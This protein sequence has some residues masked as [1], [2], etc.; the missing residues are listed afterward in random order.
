MIDLLVRSVG[1]VTDA[2]HC[3]LFPFVWSDACRDIDEPVAFINFISVLLILLIL[4]ACKRLM[5]SLYVFV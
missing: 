3:S 2:K 5:P 4:L 1:L